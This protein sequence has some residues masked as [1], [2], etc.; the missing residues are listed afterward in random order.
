MDIII[1]TKTKFYIYELIFLSSSKDSISEDG[2]VLGTKGWP[3]TENKEKKFFDIHNLAKYIYLPK[4]W[5]TCLKGILFIRD[6]NKKKLLNP[7]NPY[8]Y[9]Q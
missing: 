1:N 5:P 8:I 2:K 7:L 3:I 9:Y 6:N 4:V